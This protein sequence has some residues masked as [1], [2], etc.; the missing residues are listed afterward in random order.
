[1]ESKTLTLSKEGIF[2]DGTWF[3]HDYFECGRISGKGWYMNH[4]WMPQRSFREALAIIDY[5]GLDQTARVLDV[6][7][8]KGFLVRALRELEINAD[9]CDISEYA[10][11]SAPQGCWHCA[12]IE[13]WKKRNKLYTHAF[14]K[15][16]LEH[17]TV[18]QLRNT[19]NAISYVTS[20]MLCIVPLGDKGK[21]RIP[22]YHVD[23]SHIIAENEEWWRQIF[24]QEGWDVVGEIYH[25]PGL[26]D[27][28]KD[29]AL[30][31]GNLVLYVEYKNVA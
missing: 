1:M 18:E 7:C 4:R 10:L 14:I 23:A 28:W 26:K 27:N 5:L 3:D 11:S 12:S 25:I 24:I 19:L 21:Y 9:G 13:E 16:V 22:Q 2:P 30:G 20:R 8:A 29:S 31:K 15:D 17:N 6:G